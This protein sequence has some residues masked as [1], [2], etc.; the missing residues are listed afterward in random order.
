MAMQVTSLISQGETS[1]CTERLLPYRTCLY[2]VSKVSF[3]LALGFAV[4]SAFIAALSTVPTPIALIACASLS[5]GFVI[6]SAVLALL[7]DFYFPL[8]QK[9]LESKEEGTAPFK[10]NELNSIK[11]AQ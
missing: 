8:S 5:I 3:V 7:L 4:A 10:E 2:T 6:I 9:A 1:T 11:S